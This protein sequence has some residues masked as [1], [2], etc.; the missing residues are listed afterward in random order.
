[1]QENPVWNREV[2]GRWRRPLTIIAFFGYAA[3]LAVVAGAYYESNIVNGRVVFEQRGRVGQ[4]LF[5]VLA[6]AQLL[7]SSLFATALTATA[8]VSERE[9]GTLILL[10]L[11]PISLP[12]IIQGKYSSAVLLTALLILV[13]LPMSSLAFVM[14]G[15]SAPDFCAVTLIQIA[16]AFFFAALGLTCSAL[17][18]TASQSLGIGFSLTTLGVMLPIGVL[19]LLNSPDFMRIAA[20]SSALAFM[21]SW[22]L[23]RIATIRAEEDRYDENRV[24]E[25]S[26]VLPE[27]VISPTISPE[28]SSALLPSS[29]PQLASRR[30][31]R[32]TPLGKLLRFNNPVFERQLRKHMR[33]FCESPPEQ[34]K[35]RLTGMVLLWLAWNGIWAY[36]AVRLYDELV[37]I[38]M[39]VSAIIVVMAAT[40]GATSSFTR[41]RSQNM[42]SA[43]LLTPLSPRDVAGG[44]R[45]AALAAAGFYLLLTLPSFIFGFALDSPAASLTLLATL[46]FAALGS[47]IGLLCAW[48][49][50]SPGIA[51]A[52]SIISFLGIIFAITLQIN[53]VLIAL[54]DG[55]GRLAS[56]SWAPFL[57]SLLQPADALQIATSAAVAS[58]L[59]L[60]LSTWLMRPVLHGLQPAALESDGESWL[61]RDLSK[62]F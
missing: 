32:L 57:S 59:I 7:L 19:E 62:A 55:T 52:G 30:R 8:I 54:N 2:R 5:L 31:N 45:D 46:L 6:R 4:D 36:E 42:L 61:S 17:S 53:N 50:P 49:C 56:M 37:Q 28:A 26:Q 35:W 38:W 51:V 43:L 13:P 23:V 40:L 1:M 29:M 15:V 44:K 21:V 18:R 14:G 41:E 25:I 11:T 48:L 10:R 3:A 9:S 27:P 60:G 47:A 33:I 20:L 16:S 34:W 22:M 58:V 12:R 24:V 39:T